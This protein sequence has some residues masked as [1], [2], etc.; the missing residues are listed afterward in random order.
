LNKVEAETARTLNPVVKLAALIMLSVMVVMISST[1]LMAGIVVIVLATK[2][3]FGVRGA[4][5]KGVM[6]FAL[7]IFLAQIVFNHSGDGLYS[8]WFLRITE[9][10]VTSGIT[11]AGKFLSLIMMSWIL[12]ATTK[13]TE[14]SSALIG[15]G[16]PYRYGYL[17]ALAMRFVPIFEVELNSVR[18]AQIVRGLRLDRSVRGLIRSA[19]YTVLPMF[20]TAMFR[21]NSLAS[22]MTGRGFGAYPKRTLLHP[23]RITRLDVA[24][25]FATF[26]AAA[27]AILVDRRLNQDL[28]QLL[29]F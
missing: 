8:A 15:V 24:Y 27:T 1:V 16:V 25:A 28:M 22:S 2:Q 19:K 29:W 21:V 26:L 4:F 5:T 6:G 20:F 18:E 11:I 14:L 7:A 10:G 12:V 17:P 23:S 3:W 13:P 9:G